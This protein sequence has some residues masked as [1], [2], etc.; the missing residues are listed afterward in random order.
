MRLLITGFLAKPI[1]KRIDTEIVGEIEY[2]LSEMD[3]AYFNQYGELSEDLLTKI[4]HSA[5]RN[6]IIL[7]QYLEHKET[8]GKTLIFAL[9]Q[10]HA[11]TLCDVFKQA[12]VRCDYVVSDKPGAQQTISDFKAN[13]FDV[14]INVQ[15]LTE[16]SDIPDIH[17]VFLTRQTNSDSM[18]MQMIG[19]GLRGP[20]A[21]GTKEVYII[22]FHDTWEK[23]NIWLDPQAMDIFGSSK[24]ID[25]DD[26]DTNEHK[27]KSDILDDQPK[28]LPVVITQTLDYTL[29]D[30]Y[31]SIYN[32]MKSN[33]KAGVKATLFPCGWYSIIDPDG[34]D[35]K[36]LL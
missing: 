12:G 11:R 15:I 21:G 24:G 30:V 19:R 25:N 18:L 23:F 26:D 35:R 31:L 1:Y 27:P 28:D 9:N 13:K 29:W 32:S 7:K 17:C 8:Y 6:E 36:V 22:D 10:E 20:A 4:A 2:K 16:G 34:E 14:L 5:A 33:L 3:E